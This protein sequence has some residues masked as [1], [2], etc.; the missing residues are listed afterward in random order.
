MQQYLLNHQDRLNFTLHLIAVPLFISAHGFALYAISQQQF[1]IAA[2]VMTLAP[3]SLWLQKQGHQ[4]E[5]NQ[6]PPFT[7]PLNFLS[8]LYKEQF[9]TFPLSLLVRITRL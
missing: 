2:L 6:P 8:R 1:L 7:G 3:V 5:P 9:F 4:R